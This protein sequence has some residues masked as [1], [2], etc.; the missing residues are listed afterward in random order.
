MSHHSSPDGSV[1]VFAFPPSLEFYTVDR[2]SH[3]QIL[4]IYNPYE[5]TL[6]FKGLW[7]SFWPPYTFE[8]SMFHASLAVRLL[9]SSEI[10]YIRIHHNSHRVELNRS[11]W[12]CFITCLWS[13]TS[14]LLVLVGPPQVISD[15][16]LCIK[17]YDFTH[18]I[19]S[20]NKDYINTTRVDTYTM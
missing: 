8:I 5:F 19:K 9:G 16:S 17:S 6:K 12:K 13:Q 1:P 2:S 15:R 11:I 18:H 14:I 7:I 4:T 3:K 10:T 20:V